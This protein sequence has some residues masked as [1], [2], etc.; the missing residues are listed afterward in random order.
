MG[1]LLALTALFAWG[2]GDFLIQRSARKFGDWLALFYITTF[3]AI[4][5]FPFVYKDIGVEFAANGGLLLLTSAV[6][7]VASLVDFEALKVG[8]IS[9]VEP[10]YAME[11]PVTATLA[12]L[13]LQEGLTQI[14]VLLV[15]AAVLGIFLIS[16][17]SFHHFKRIHLEKGIWY[18]VLATIGMGTANFL[19]GHA[20][21]E[22]SPLMINWFTGAFMAVVTLVYLLVKGQG[23]E[24][25]SDLRHHKRLIVNMAFFDV[26]AW[27]AFAYATTYIPIAIATSISEAYIVLASALG[28]V[29]NRE[30]LKSHQFLGFALTV[31]AIIVLAMITT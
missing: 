10:I 6:I 28:W 13:L 29:Y 30:R 1:V 3:G 4:V 24:I 25:L 22:V 2:L 27:V 23:G 17:R 9:V 16:T 5:L 7:L 12:A 20:A 26:L 11:I 31:G 15:A 8:K 18:A 19:F 21:R 14:Q